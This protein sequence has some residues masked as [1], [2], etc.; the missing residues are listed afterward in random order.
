[1]NAM[2]HAATPH[3]RAAALAGSARVR[4][5]IAPPE[6]RLEAACRTGMTAFEA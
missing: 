6:L 4:V 2:M 1:M 3:P 5:R